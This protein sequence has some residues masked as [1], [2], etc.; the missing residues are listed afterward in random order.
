MIY[1]IKNMS[2]K[3][4]P[5]AGLK[6][7]IKLQNW[8]ANAQILMYCQFLIVKVIFIICLNVQNRLPE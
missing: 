6:D 1:F 5:G 3:K 8:P 7:I 4:K 2:V